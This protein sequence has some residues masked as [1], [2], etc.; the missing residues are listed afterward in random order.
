MSVELFPFQHDDILNEVF[1]SEVMVFLKT[2]PTFFTGTQERLAATS[3]IYVNH[4]SLSFVFTLRY[5]ASK[6]GK[7]KEK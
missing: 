6:K 1:T 5:G 4:Y 3:G 2:G 7:E